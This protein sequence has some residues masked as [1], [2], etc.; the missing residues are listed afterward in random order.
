M[1][2]LVAD[3]HQQKLAR[4]RITRR[5]AYLDRKTRQ[6]CVDCAAGLQED[7]GLK[8]VECGDRDKAAKAG[9]RTT[10]EVR[11]REAVSR[12]ARRAQ[13]IANGKC[14]HCGGKRDRLE[15]RNC[16]DC[17][18]MIL[19]ATR[20]Y[21]QRKRAGTVGTSV[22]VERRLELVR[23]TDAPS[24]YIPIDDR[25]RKPSTRVLRAMR[26]LDWSPAKEVLEACDAPDDV[27]TAER[28]TLMST[29]CRM[30][31]RG[32]VEVRG[33][34]G[35]REYRLTASG[36]EAVSFAIATVERVS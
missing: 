34:L 25:L 3:R 13:W 16:A 1:S 19:V 27:R 30:W 10:P 14:A 6:V 5:A 7:D 17:R 33:V 21:R 32:L 8:C 26:F 11:A 18:E 23:D 15:V 29:L 2:S 35:A 4:M 36:R 24:R 20:S 31:K 22:V 9:R 28:S 12:R